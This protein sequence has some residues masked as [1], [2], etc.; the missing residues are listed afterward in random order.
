VAVRAEPLQIDD[1]RVEIR[2]RDKILFP[3]DGITK[4]ELVEHYR[5]IASRTLPHLQ[6]RPLAMECYPDGIDRPGF[7]R[8]NAP[9][10]FPGWIRTVPI[11]KKAGGMVRHVVCNDVAALLYLAN[12]ACITPHTGSAGSTSSPVPI[13][14]CSIWILPATAS[15]R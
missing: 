12:Q 8:K 10:W 4:R 1:R 7:F 3:D 9:S 2:H 14:W 5:R 6:H 15:G 13:R 11:P